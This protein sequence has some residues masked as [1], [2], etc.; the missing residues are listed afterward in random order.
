MQ[1]LVVEFFALNVLGCMPRYS[2]PIIADSKMDFL[3]VF[4]EQWHDHKE[5]NL[6]FSICGKSFCPQ[7]H[8]NMAGDLVLP[9][10]FTVDEWFEK[11]Y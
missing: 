2:F 11:G 8:T 7:N 1:R 6:P 10:L 4:T 9:D 5:A 3:Q